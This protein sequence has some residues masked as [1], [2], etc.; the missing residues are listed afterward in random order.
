MVEHFGGCDFGVP[1]VNVEGIF[2]VV[3]VLPFGVDVEEEHISPE[4]VFEPVGVVPAVTRERY[5]VQTAASWKTRGQRGTY[6]PS[7]L[8]CRF[9]NQ[10]MMEAPKS[11]TSSEPIRTRWS[12]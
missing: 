4:H 2:E 7:V 5:R 3:G 10:S 6:S 11:A 1:V 12:L 9:S 8:A